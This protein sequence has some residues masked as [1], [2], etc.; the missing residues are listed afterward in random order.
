MTTTT[1]IDEVRDGKHFVHVEIFTPSLK[2]VLAPKHPPKSAFYVDGV[3]VDQQTFMAL[4]EVGENRIDKLLTR[5]VTV[6]EE[7]KQTGT[8]SI[9][10]VAQ[11]EAELT[12]D[13]EKT[14]K[15][16]LSK[17]QYK[18]V[19]SPELRDFLR[20]VSALGATLGKG[21]EERFIALMSA[22]STI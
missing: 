3:Q 16:M 7:F 13:E 21:I 14:R 6:M 18:D 19:S 20:R 12:P 9:E 11:I 2:S 22:K 10:T 17:F 4:Y 8:V 5:A 1:K 15:V